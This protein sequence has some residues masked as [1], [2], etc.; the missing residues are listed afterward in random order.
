MESSIILKIARNGEI[1]AELGKV[2][3]FDMPPMACSS[4][5]SID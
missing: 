2:I 1:F 5:F 3:D 4:T